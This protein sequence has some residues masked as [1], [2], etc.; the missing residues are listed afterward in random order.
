MAQELVLRSPIPLQ[1]DGGMGH[2]FQ[3][4]YYEGQPDVPT[5]L[6]GRSLADLAATS[7]DDN[8]E[9]SDNG[10][11]YDGSVIDNMA[12][13]LLDSCNEDE[14]NDYFSSEG[15]TTATTRHEHALGNLQTSFSL[16]PASLN[17]DSSS[18]IPGA[19]QHFR[20]PT[21]PQPRA[22]ETQ[23]GA[24]GPGILSP[25]QLGG[26]IVQHFGNQ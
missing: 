21:S 7:V 10:S 4:G 18:F 26:G 6:H 25:A 5:A 1:P 17:L 23:G 2:C 9:G 20:S 15:P 3:S 12:S 14:S 22:A 16:G 11:D 24:A 8:S 19:G 13:L